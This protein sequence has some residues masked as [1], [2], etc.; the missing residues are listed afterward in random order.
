MASPETATASLP[1]AWIMRGSEE[2][3]K[4]VLKPFRSLALA[5]GV[6]EKQSVTGPDLADVG[7]V[8]QALVERAEVILGIPDGSF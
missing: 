1:C 8:V 7:V 6:D 4:A 5:L 2:R 3:A